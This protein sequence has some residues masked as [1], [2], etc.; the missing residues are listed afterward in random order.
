MTRKSLSGA[1]VALVAVLGMSAEARPLKRA[2][3][4]RIKP[5][6]KPI[7]CITIRA[8]QSSRVR[9]DRTIDFYMSGDRVYRD[10]LPR[11]CPGLGTEEMFSFTTD[12][13]Q[14]CYV[15]TITVLHGPSKTRGA[16]CGLGHFQPIT[17]APR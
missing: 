3:E 13:P 1:L 2:E 6:G 4:A 12:M 10:R 15:D 14:L 5:A 8:I 7:K 16:N 11:R 9:D 17:G